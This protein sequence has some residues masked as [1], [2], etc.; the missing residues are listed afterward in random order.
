MRTALFVF[1]AFLLVVGLRSEN[2][3]GWKKR[4]EWAFQMWGKF[5][6]TPTGPV[7]ADGWELTVTFPEPIGNLEQW[8]WQ[9]SES[10]N[11]DKTEYVIKC[12]N[13]CL[14][15]NGKLKEGDTTEYDF[16]VTKTTQRPMEDIEVSFEL[17]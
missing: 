12:E 15:G 7:D 5:N 11:N 4:S 9:A 3:V 1:A 2:E 10:H 16:T 13:L 6:I 17:L 8:V 14:Y